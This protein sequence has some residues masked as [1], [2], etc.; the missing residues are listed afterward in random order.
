MAVTFV[1]DSEGQ[2]EYQARDPS[3]GSDTFHQGRSE[4]SH[5]S[6]DDQID[7]KFKRATKHEVSYRAITPASDETV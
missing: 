4:F 5:F 7:A 3:A 2:G 6:D 1:M